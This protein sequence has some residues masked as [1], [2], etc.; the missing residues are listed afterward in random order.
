MIFLVSVLLLTNFNQ[1]S[2]DQWR[3]LLCQGRIISNRYFNYAE[4]FSLGMPR[5]FKGRAGQAAGPERGVSIPLSHDCSGVVVVDGAPNSFEWLKPIA[6]TKWQIDSA[7]K[8]DPNVKV[9][10]YRTRLGK[11]KAAGVT[12]RHQATA[13]VEEIVIAFRP[14]GAIVYTARLSTNN[15]RYTRDDRLFRKV[16]R[17]FRLEAWR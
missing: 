12:I 2:H 3:K 16:L 15:S 11:L 5:G 17:A 4:G 6:A 1:E 13:E 8:Y 7:S 14:G 10:Q 9:Q